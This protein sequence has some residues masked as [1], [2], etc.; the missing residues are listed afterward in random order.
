MEK[1]VKYYMNGCNCAEAMILGGNDYYGLK[2]PKE[3]FL[4][5]A[6]FGGGVNREDLCGAVSGG[7]ALL[8]LLFVKERSHDS[9]MI[10][11][12]TKEYVNRFEASMGSLNCKKL[13]EIH[14]NDTEKCSAVVEASS[15]V[16]EEIVEEYAKH[17]VR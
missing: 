8:G 11:E 10:G 6:A 15:R 13:K 2:L 9:G 5:M 7:V 1:T 12:I 14:R 16:L 17:R 3:S 4:T